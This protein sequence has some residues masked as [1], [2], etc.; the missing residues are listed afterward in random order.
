MDEVRAK[1]KMKTTDAAARWCL[2]NDVSI[3]KI[4]NKNVVV[5][6]EFR[7]ILEKPVIDRLKAIHGDSWRKF[8]A[9]YDSENVL[10]FFELENTTE[11]DVAP[12][13]AYNPNNFLTQID[14]GKA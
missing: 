11:G 1:L 5:E 6:Y 7:L 9:A 14:Y 10:N 12:T 2:A 4:G 8:Y 3:L 13:V